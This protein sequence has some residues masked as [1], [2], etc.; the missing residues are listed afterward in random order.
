MSAQPQEATL[1]LGHERPSAG[2]ALYRAAR[3]ARGWPIRREAVCSAH[4]RCTQAASGS[5]PSAPWRT[6]T[7]AVT[8]RRTRLT[9]RSCRTHLHNFHPPHLAR[10][11]AALNNAAG[12]AA[13]N[14]SLTP[15]SSI[16][17]NCPSRQPGSIADGVPLRPSAQRSHSATCPRA[18]I[19]R[20]LASPLC[21]N[22]R[23][24]AAAPKPILAPGP[25]RPRSV[26]LGAARVP[27]WRGGRLH[28]AARAAAAAAAPPPSLARKLRRRAR[29]RC[30][31]GPRRPRPRPAPR[32]PPGGAAR[33]CSPRPGAR[34]GRQGRRAPASAS[35]RR[36]CCC[37][38]EP[39][40]TRTARWPACKAL[41]PGQAAS[42]NNQS[43][44]PPATPLR[45]RRGAAGAR[46]VLGQ[47][48][49]VVQAVVLLQL[50]AVL[51]QVARHVLARQPLHV[52]QLRR[53]AARS[54]RP[55]GPAARARLATFSRVSPSTFI[56][57]AGCVSS[58]E[59]RVGVAASSVACWRSG[60][61]TSNDMHDTVT[62]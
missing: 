42:P 3:D 7:A 36:G 15:P 29:G 32:R 10:S 12:A 54:G 57:C 41:G 34:A 40:D 20:T 33:P 24:G 5:V 18:A 53:A 28:V 26:R 55:Q 48:A 19:T 9:S 21:Q 8:P 38:L 27:R 52:H 49:V 62:L 43:A 17:P 14:L 59:R 50:Q 2:R 37:R 45:G 60:L 61:G 44:A 31:A 11:Q 16:L 58:H 23:Q 22:A 47:V 56:S 30:R 13:R 1:S 39:G 6:C 51:L 25:P 46:R 4:R 35:L